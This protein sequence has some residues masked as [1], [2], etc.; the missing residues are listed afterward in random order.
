MFTEQQRSVYQSIQAPPE[1]REK[2]LGKKKT[3]RKIPAYIVT[4]VAACLVLAMGIGMFLPGGDIGV[5]CN[6]QK[7]ENSI[8]YYDLATAYETR[9]ATQ[10]SVPVELEL[11][12]KSEISVTK[13][14]LIREGEDVGEHLTAASKVS[15]M[16]QLPRGE[17]NFCCEMTVT[18]EEE[19]TTITLN[20]EN[21]KITITKKGD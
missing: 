5:I 16:W 20:Y 2:I 11:S 3:N 8:V 19:V 21:S 1:L 14:S 12:E 10:I 13:G 9:G 18:G 15:L 17:E 7:L 4:A 6:G